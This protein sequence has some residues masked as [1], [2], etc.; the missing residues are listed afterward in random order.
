MVRCSR[1]LMLQHLYGCLPGNSS[2]V[3][4]ACQ[5]TYSVGT[6]CMRADIFSYNLYV[7]I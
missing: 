2:I 1:Q 7:Y 5:Y 3:S 6:T 4:T